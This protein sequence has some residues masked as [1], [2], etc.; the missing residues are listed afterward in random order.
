MSAYPQEIQT[1]LFDAIGDQITLWQTDSKTIYDAN[2]IL[3]FLNIYGTLQP[4]LEQI[5]NLA[6]ENHARIDVDDEDIFVYNPKGITEADQQNLAQ[7][8]QQISQ[9]LKR[10]S[11]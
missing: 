3:A 2:D 6:T 11:K 8:I 7:A 9:F 5:K 1:N 10:I 4:N